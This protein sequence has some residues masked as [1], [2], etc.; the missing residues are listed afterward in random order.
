[1]T[2]EQIIR[3]SDILNTQVIAKDNGKRLGVI[4]QL[5]VDIDRREVV[6]MGLRDNLIAFA[7]VPRYMYLNSVN[8]IGDVVLVDNEDVIEDIDVDVYSNVVNCEV[9]TETGELLGRVRNFKFNAETGTLTSLIIASLGLPQ[10]PD[11]VISTYEISI[12]EVV[13]SGPNRIIVFEGAEERV[14]QLTVGLLERLGIGKAPWEREEEEAYF[15]PTAKPE[16]QLGTGVP[17]QAPVK[18]MRA[19]QPVEQTWDEDDYEYEPLQPAPRQQQRYQQQYESIQ[20]A[21]EEY[22]DNWSEA[23]GR[24]RYSEPPRYVEPEPYKEPGYSDDYRYEDDELTQD[25]WDDD[26]PKPVNIPKKIKQPEYEEEDRY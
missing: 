5:W 26:E 7:G 9:I 14:T 1:M 11:Q 2:S 19:T 22:E 16:N 21:E 23:S 17:L 25:V 24:D 6:A 8:Q 13:S 15:T 12:D 20:Y 10:I 18:P 3:R 4:N